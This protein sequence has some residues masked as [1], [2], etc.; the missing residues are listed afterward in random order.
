MTATEFWKRG[1]PLSEAWF[2]YSSDKL[3]RKYNFAKLSRTISPT[4]GLGMVLKR[5]A[6]YPNRPKFEKML[7]RM[8]HESEFRQHRSDVKKEMEFD[9]L[10]KLQEGKLVAYGYLAG[11][12]IKAPPVE[13]PDRF[14][15]MKFIKWE[16]DTISAPPHEFSTVRIVSPIVPKPISY[17]IRKSK[18]IKKRGR[19]S[20]QEHV[21]EA[22]ALIAVEN[23][24]QLHLPHKRLVPIIR[25]KIHQLHPDDY[26]PDQPADRTIMRMIPSGRKTIIKAKR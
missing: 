19:P 8:T 15:E 22:M 2:Q 4:S 9:V 11:R 1:I 25:K 10:E 23:P 21:F 6:E 17:Q 26:G 18:E 24:T 5:L 3:Y 16:S 20:V 12:N 14:L 13:I 7:I